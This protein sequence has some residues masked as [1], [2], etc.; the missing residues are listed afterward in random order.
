MTADRSMP[1]PGEGIDLT[2]L[3]WPE[4]RE[5]L[6]HNGYAPFTERVEENITLVTAAKRIPRQGGGL[7]EVVALGMT[8]FLDDGRHTRYFR[9]VDGVLTR[10]GVLVPD[11]GS[12]RMGKDRIQDKYKQD[13]DDGL[14]VPSMDDARTLLG[15]LLKVTGKLN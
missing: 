10:A 8:E 15:I 7:C 12:N 2:L 4:F 9:V 11:A 6:R 13:K 3:G 5:R 14:L 1:N